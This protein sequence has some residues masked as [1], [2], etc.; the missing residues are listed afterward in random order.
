MLAGVPAAYI[1]GLKAVE[2][3]PRQGEVGAPYGAYLPRDRTIW[4]Y[5]C[6]PETWQF[7]AEAWPDHTGI[8][9]YGARLAAH[10]EDPA[11]VLVE[12]DDPD[13][14][15]KSYIHTLLHELGH[16]Y[17]NQYRSSRGRPSSR[18]REEGLADLHYTKILDT[19]M[20]MRARR[21]V[22]A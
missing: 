20:R 19:L 12:W 7:T 10:Q 13:G 17:V 4:L 2:L 14:V 5:S 1:Y 21:R 6:P 22:G 15:W 16:H 9:S 8:L 11:R 3:R 18:K